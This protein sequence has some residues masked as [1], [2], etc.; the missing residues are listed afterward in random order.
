MTYL[1]NL[2]SGIRETKRTKFIRNFMRLFSIGLVPL[3]AMVPSV[4]KR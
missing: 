3:G 1:A 4:S 2:S